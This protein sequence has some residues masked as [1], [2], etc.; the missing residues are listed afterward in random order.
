M[1]IPPPPTQHTHTHTQYPW[2]GAWTVAQCT[3]NTLQ[4]H[5]CNVW[6]ELRILYSITPHSG[7]GSHHA[8]Q[9]D[10]KLSILLPQPSCC[11]VC[12][13][14]NLKSEAIDRKQFS[15]ESQWYLHFQRGTGFL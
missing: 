3:G 8:A 7:T 4:G 14:L 5:Q 11:W 12:A 6:P 13:A 10:L 2:S 9:V 15:R 1:V